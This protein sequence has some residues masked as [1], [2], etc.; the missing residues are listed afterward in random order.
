LAEFFGP[1]L[2]LRRLRLWEGGL[3]AWGC[4]RAL[5]NAIYF[6]P[7][8]QFPATRRAPESQAL[9][10]HEAVHVWQCQQQGWVYA[11][12]SLKEQA[13][14]WLQTQSRRA[15]YQYILQPERPLTAYGVEQQAQLLEDYFRWRWQ[16]DDRGVRT[17][18]G[19]F[20]RLGS[21]RAAAL[22][23]ARYQELQ[24]G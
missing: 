14:A 6:D 18:C 3:F 2:D 5:G 1:A 13:W 19:D 9:L 16:G 24:R 4:T 22:L 15:A 17:N 8:T 11:V 21:V 23:E 7:R 10:V 12:R 20:A